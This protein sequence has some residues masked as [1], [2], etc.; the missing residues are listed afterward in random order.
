[1]VTTSPVSYDQDFALWLES[2]V[3]LLKAGEFAGVDWEHLIEEIEGLTRSDKRELENRLI[4]LFEHALKRCYVPFPDCYRGWDVT[5]L[6]TQK[7]IQRI[8]KDSPSLR[9]YLREILEASYQEAW[10][11]MSQEYDASFPDQY[12]FSKDLAILLSTSFWQ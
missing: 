11:D 10:E 5:L 2:T 8:L 1:M 12:P 3:Q 6:R 7:Q 9:N 4:T